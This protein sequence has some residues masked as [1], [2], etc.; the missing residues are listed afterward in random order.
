[1]L[2][3]KGA[4]YDHCVLLTKLYQLFSCFILHSKTQ[5][6]YYSGYLSTLYIC[7]P[8][9]QDENVIPFYVVLEGVVGLHKTHQFHLLQH[10]WLQYELDHCDVEWFALE[11]NPDPVFFEVATKYCISDTFIDYEGYSI[12]SKGFLP[13]GVDIIVI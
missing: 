11:M 12:S 4:C 13:T 8:V 1:M 3:E 9:P 6:T 5:L 7:I 10:R 2:F